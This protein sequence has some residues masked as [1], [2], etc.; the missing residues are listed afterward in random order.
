MDGK[1][2]EDVQT[3]RIEKEKGKEINLKALYGTLRKRL[4]LIALMTISLAVIAGIYNSRPE[5]PL[6]AAS[7][8][9]IVAASSE[10]MGTARVL[11]REPIVLNKVA[12]ELGLNRSAAGLRGQIRLDSAEGSL[13]TVVTV[14]DPDAR[15]AA[16]IANTSVEVYRQVAAETLGVSSIRVLTQAEESSFPINEKS[17]TIVFAAL[18]VGLIMSIALTFLLDSLD[19]SIKSEQEAQ[20]LLGLTMLGQVSQMKRKDHARASKKQKSIVARG[21]TIG[22]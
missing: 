19:D 14:V 22:S 7:S 18:I 15:L 13:I 6:Y 17:N 8:R 5:T 2:L 4:W 16:E 9:I 11:F 12:E 20:E 10:M 21:E 3:E 1:Q